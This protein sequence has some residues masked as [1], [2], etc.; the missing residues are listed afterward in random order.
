V[1]VTAEVPGYNGPATLIVYDA[2]GRFAGSF[3]TTLTN[4]AGSFEVVPRGALGPAWGALFVGGNLVAENGTLFVLD[5]QT[6][7]VTGLPRFDGFVAGVAALLAQDV[8]AYELDGRIVH[9][10]RSPDSPLLWLRDHVYQGRGFRYFDRQVTSALDAFQ[11]AQYADGSFPDFLSRPE[12]LVEAWR[13]PVE[14]DVE[15]LY[16]QGVC[17]AHQLTGDDAWLQ[18]HLESMRRAVLYTL[19]D[20]LRWDGARELVKRPF[21][22]DTWDFEYGPTTIDPRSGRAAPRHWIDERTIWGVFHGDNT[23]LAHALE[24]L[25]RAE[26]RVGDAN[27]AQSW[28][29][30]AAGLIGRINALSW[31][32]RFFRHHIPE[33]PFDVPGVDEAEQLSLSNA[34]VL[35]RGVL[36]VAQ[37]QAIV[38]EY[39]ARLQT[40]RAFAE[41]FSIDPPFP[42]GSYGLAGRNGELPGEYVNGGIMPLVGGELARGA[43]RYGYEGYG[44]NI[45]ERY[46]LRMLSVGRSFLWYRPDGAEGVGTDDTLPTDGWGSSAMLG[47]LIEGAAGIED[48]GVAYNDVVVSPRWSATPDVNE[49]YAVARYAASEGYVAYRWRRGFDGLALQLSTSAERTRLRLLLPPEA[50]EALTVQL[51]GAPTT[52]VVETVLFSRYV[53]LD[54]PDVVADVQISFP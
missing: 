32:G 41:W 44:F 46:W 39:L 27:L 43:F 8:I 7:L 49:A 11:R 40:T 14:A 38:A 5:A 33:R 42:G 45:L 1:V 31:N 3:E 15:F 53:V 16:V 6:T 30:I 29:D 4:G 36:S 37:G 12:F 28:R 18:G 54:V 2:R 17:E 10:Y 51:N 52:F 20:P 47:G 25:A 26:E 24:L 34:L 35:N 48:A 22:I 13:T 21:T 19:R 23:G 50:G 9:G